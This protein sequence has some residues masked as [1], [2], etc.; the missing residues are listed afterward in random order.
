MNISYCLGDLELDKGEV[1]TLLSHSP[2]DITVTIDLKRHIKAVDSKKL[3]AQA[4]ADKDTRLAT[5]AA[6]LAME[7]GRKFNPTTKRT[8]RKT[9]EKSVIPSQVIEQDPFDS[10]EEILSKKCLKN[11]GAAMILSSLE[12]GNRSS[13]RE[14][15]EDIVTHLEKFGQNSPKDSPRLFKGFENSKHGFRALLS[16][17]EGVKPFHQSPTY[18]A[19]RDGLK[20]LASVGLVD[21][22]SEK[23]YGAVD[24]KKKETGHLQRSVFTVSLTKGAVKLMR[25]WSD[26][27]DY[28]SAFWKVVA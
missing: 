17:K 20:Y 8:Y 1:K 23:T 22:K 13:L 4:I 27:E 16:K 11:V 9:G 5:L 14:I 2:D 7:G 21:I 15:G 10:M 28:I 12:S 3:F 18:T 26:C 6:K 24:Q 19:L 25:N